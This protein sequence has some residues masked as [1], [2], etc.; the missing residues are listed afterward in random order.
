MI[1]DGAPAKAPSI[2]RR[3]AIGLGVASGLALANVS[4]EVLGKSPP[5]TGPLDQQAGAAWQFATKISY[6]CAT[7][8]FVVLYS[9]DNFAGEPQLLT[10]PEL[11]SKPQSGPMPAGWGAKSGSM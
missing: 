5:T 9:E 7:G 8:Y 1:P 6:K 11:L 4:T 2:N 3:T 10:K